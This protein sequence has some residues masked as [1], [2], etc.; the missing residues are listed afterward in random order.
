MMFLA[1]F[2]LSLSP[3]HAHKGGWNC[4]YEHTKRGGHSSG[5]RELLISDTEL[6]QSFRNR[7]HGF[8]LGLEGERLTFVAMANNETKVVTL[9]VKEAWGKNQ[10]PAVLSLSAEFKN[11]AKSS[12]TCK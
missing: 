10:Q 8:D 11:G 2:V 1:L 5:P 6:K 3:V 7:G 9:Q 12:V 4:V